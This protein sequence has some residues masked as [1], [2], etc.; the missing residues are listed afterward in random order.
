MDGSY[1]DMSSVKSGVPQGTVMGPILFLLFINDLPSVV[2][3]ETQ[4]HLFADDCL[5]YRSIK[6]VHD[7]VQLQRDLDALQ[8]WG[9]LWEMSFNASKCNIMSLS[10]SETPLVKFYELSR[11]VLQQVDC[12]TY[13]GISLQSP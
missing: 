11:T 7:Q 10:S 2:D 13:L 3:P 4:V 1:S 9:D 6:S 12:A 5:I 8:L